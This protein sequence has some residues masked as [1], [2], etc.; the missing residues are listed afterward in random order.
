MPAL[1]EAI[2]RLDRAEKLDP[3]PSQALYADRALYHAALGEAKEAARDRA[4]RDATR[5]TTGRDFYLIGT[6]LLAQGQPDRAE[7]ALARATGLDP[8]RFWG[9]FAL[10]LC[11]YDQGRFAESAGDFAICAVLAPKFSW[12]WMNRGLALARAGRL[13]E[14]RE[15]YDRAVEADPK[16]AEA[17]ANRALAALELGD[18]PAAVADLEKAVALGLDDP[19]MR[20]AL[21][22]ALVRVGPPRGR[23]PTCSPT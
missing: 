15:A 17:L 22:E 14:A 10:G 5:P 4:R 18:A 9:W 7:P 20:A 13:V 1:E 23:A 8:R 11:H 12:P 19:S 3:I 6:A 21:G 16:N 2:A